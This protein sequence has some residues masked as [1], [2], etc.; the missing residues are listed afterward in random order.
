MQQTTKSN[1][2]ATTT[3]ED[4]QNN[5]LQ[6]IDFSA[7]YLPNIQP[8]S[9][10][11]SGP[12]SS[13]DNRKNNILQDQTYLNF[14]AIGTE[15]G[16][17]HLSIFGTFT[18]VVLNL[19]D[20]LEYTYKVL[21]V[22]FSEDLDVMFVTV[23]DVFKDVRILVYNTEVFKSHLKELFVMASKH[24]RLMN[25]TDSLQ[26]TITTITETWENILL[27]IDTKLSKYAAKMP[28]GGVTADFLDLLMFGIYSEELEEFLVHDI[29]KKGLEKFGTTIEMS[30][31]HIQKLLLKYVLKIGQNIAYHLSELRGLARLEHRYKVCIISS[32][33]KKMEIIV[34][35]ETFRF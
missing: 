5:P 6:F 11:S 15:D 14:L 13:E 28:K 3:A 29:G 31:T 19:C 2:S 25:L 12:N 21:N 8:L 35:V 1:S 26:V 34:I 7:T 20:K 18:C 27:E 30:Y 24:E 4:E 9:N 10:Y 33:K 16:F 22:H 32:K 17:L 23:F